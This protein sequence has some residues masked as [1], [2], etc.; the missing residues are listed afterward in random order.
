MLACACH[1]PG[2]LILLPVTRGERVGFVPPHHTCVSSVLTG[3]AAPTPLHRM[4]MDRVFPCE[5][6]SGFR[7]GMSCFPL[8]GVGGWGL[9]HLIIPAY[10]LFL[11]AAAPTPPHRMSMGRVSC[12]HVPATFRYDYPAPVTGGGKVGVQPTPDRV[13]SSVL[14]GAAAPTP[15]HRMSTGRVSCWHVP[16]TFRVWLSC[17]RLPG[18]RGQGFS[19]PRIEWCRAFLRGLP[20]SLFGVLLPG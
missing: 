1:F 9:Y 8:P 14:A 10:H 11:G 18:V 20:T 6:A 13:I 15:P 12:W 7:R 17:F 5:I 4:S 2:M 3:A 19:P 16:A